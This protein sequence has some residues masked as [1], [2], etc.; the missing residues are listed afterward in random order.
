MSAG[1]HILLI[2][3]RPGDV[4]LFEEYLLESEL[5]RYRLFHAE[6]LGA[7][8]KILYEEEIDIILAD[9][10]LPDT[11][12]FA[13]FERLFQE[14]SDYPIIVLTGLTDESLGLRAVQR[15]A[16]DF[17]NKSGM[18]GKLLSRSIKYAL[19]RHRMIHRLE[20]A[21]QLAKVG[22]W[23][24][25]LGS[26]E[27]KCS[28]QVY[29]I[30]ERGPSASFDTFDDYVRAVHPDDQEEVSTEFLKAT[31]VSGEFQVDH[32]ILCADGRVKFVALHGRSIL[33]R[34]GDAGQVVGTAQDITER[35]QVVL[36]TSEKDLAERTAKLRQDFLAKTSHEIRNPLNPILVLTDVLLNTEL[37]SKQRDYL[38]AIKSAGSNLLTVVND[39]LDLSKIEAGKIE[40][41]H[42]PFSIHSLIDHLRE[43]LTT[44]ASEKALR[45]TFDI[46][47]QVQPRLIGDSG[48]LTQI[49]MN[50]IG[51]A[52]KFTP[53]GSINLHVGQ[54]AEAENNNCVLLFTV[55]DTGIGIPE[56]KIDFIFDSFSQ[57][58]H[59]REANTSGAG[60]GLNIAHQLVTLQGGSIWVESEVNKGSTFYV[61]LPFEVAKEEAA[62][63]IK[64]SVIQSYNL[65]GIRILLVEDNQLNQL[66]TQRLLSDW[67]SYVDIADNGVQALEM[68]RQHHYDVVLMD[69]HMP[70]MDGF[71]AT[72]MIRSVTSA[73]QDISI[74]ALTADALPGFEET[75]RSAGMNDYITKP[76]E[77]NS[78]YSKIA[79][80]IPLH[81]TESAHMWVQPMEKT[82]FPSS[83]SF[84]PMSQAALTDLSYLIELTGGDSS[85]IKLT[86]EK[87][88]VQTPAALQEM[89]K[90][91]AAK[92]YRALAKVAHKL[93]VTFSYVGR[94]DILANCEEVEAA[95]HSENDY[96][97]IPKRIGKVEDQYAAMA[98]EIM[99]YINAQ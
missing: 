40:F 16:Q 59:E 53:K 77:I 99:A 29:A 43:I 74:I 20:Q 73:F 70:E 55:T 17:L 4:R 32:R 76:F 6:T 12:G 66:V 90:L 97:S 13:T 51:N 82:D 88:S 15:G 2:E 71:E 58:H 87:I 94:R 48:R 3:D 25:D 1:P 93:K 49:L 35:K 68:L 72:K 18:D 11:S 38:L 30:F 19:E 92:D 60:L 75:C 46:S 44:T 98:P 64:V 50:L 14:F 27:F 63:P 52:I 89:H 84:V 80:Q 23:D 10:F 86:L 56:N 39:I 45:L 91:Y 26:G 22:H 8:R 7:A 54:E 36:L 69:V 61:S 78:L 67:N 96:D 62:Q 24:I 28:N 95:C 33:N 85:I 42:Q 41:H 47:P 31:G 37:T 5:R 21:Q 57:A 81:V 9:L 83:N 65:N 34:P 79:S